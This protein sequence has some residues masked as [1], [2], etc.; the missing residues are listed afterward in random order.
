MLMLCCSKAKHLCKYKVVNANHSIILCLNLS[1]PTEP[2]GGEDQGSVFWRA[3]IIHS[4]IPSLSKHLLSVYLA[5]K[6]TDENT[7]L[8]KVE[9]LDVRFNRW[10]QMGK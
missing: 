6:T 9:F 5:P 3:L 8:R 2:W 10:R 7:D 1:L 4:F